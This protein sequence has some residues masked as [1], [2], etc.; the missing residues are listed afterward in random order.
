M[1]TPH[2]FQIG[3]TTY[4]TRE[5]CN[6]RGITD[7][8]TILKIQWRINTYIRNHTIQ[9]TIEELDRLTQWG[10]QN[11]T[12]TAPEL[13]HRIVH[14]TQAENQ[15]TIVINPN[16]KIST[17]TGTRPWQGTQKERII[18][19]REKEAREA[20]TGQMITQQQNGETATKAIDR[21]ELLKQSE[22][23]E[24]EEKIKAIYEAGDTENAIHQLAQVL[25]NATRL[26]K[27]LESNQ[28]L[29]EYWK[30]I[31]ANLLNAETSND[32][33]RRHNRP[34]KNWPD[35]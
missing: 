31:T 3:S 1:R 12:K 21:Q 14:K 24:R 2:T 9:Q 32:R 27:E 6:A 5:Y 35:V 33:F 29:I 30:E 4:T 7:N 22:W 10:R 15:P 11:P 20:T 17:L 23:M 8:A 34:E 13:R 19:Q 26:R 18:A 28:E 25:R 16:D